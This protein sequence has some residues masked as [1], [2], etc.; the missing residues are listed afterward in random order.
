M[1]EFDD[2]PRRY[3]HLSRIRLEDPDAVDSSW[4]SRTSS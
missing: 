1:S 2:N 3:E 4:A